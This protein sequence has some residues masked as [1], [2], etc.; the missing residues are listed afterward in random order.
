[1]KHC[2]LTVAIIS[3]NVKSGASACAGNYGAP[4]VGTRVCVAINTDTNGWQG[5]PVMFSARVP[6]AA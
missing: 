6:A 4:A 1:M 5:I 2:H 3:P